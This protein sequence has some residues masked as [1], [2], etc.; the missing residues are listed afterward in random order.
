MG[1]SGSGKSMI[2]DLLQLIFVG[3]DAF[4]SATVG[5]DDRKPSGMVLKQEKGRGTDIAYAFINI[6]IS[7]NKYLSIGTYIETSIRSTSSF[8]IQSGYDP[9]ILTPFDKPLLCEDFL[10]NEELLPIDQLKEHLENNGLICHYWQRPKHYLE[11]LFNNQILPLNLTSNDK[12]L[13]DFAQI[14]QSF[15]RGKLLNT[16]KSA[17][18]KDFLFG[19]VEAKEI[20]KEFREAVKEFESEIGEYGRNQSEIERVT[21]KQKDYLELYTRKDKLE[22]CLHEWL[23]KSY[24]Y[25]Q[26]NEKELYK[27]LVSTST[28]FISTI[29]FLNE[30]H[31][32]VD[33]ELNETDFREH[34]LKLN[35]QNA[36]SQLRE[37]ENEYL[38]LGDA[39]NVLNEINCKPSELEV[40]HRN[41]L[42][43]SNKIKAIASVNFSLIERQLEDFFHNILWPASYREFD[44]ILKKEIDAS[45]DSINKKSL[46]KNYS[47]IHDQNSLSN[48]AFNLNRPLTLEEE[49]TLLHFQSLPRLKP[50]DYKNYLPKPEEL[51]LA[52]NISEKESAGFWLNLNGIREF[53][54]Y[55]EKRIFDQSDRNAIKSFFGEY[56]KE[57]KT[58]IQKSREYVNKLKSVRSAFLSL[59]NPKQSYELYVKRDELN[60]SSYYK[61][62]DFDKET[63][64]KYLS[65]LSKE[66]KIEGSYN[67]AKEN[68]R[69]TI[70]E[71]TSF[72]NQNKGLKKVKEI[73]IWT[74][75]LST[76]EQALIDKFGGQDLESF[77]S[78]HYKSDL[79]NLI[80]V[81][82]GKKESI[83][84][85]DFI[86]IYDTYK[87][88]IS[89]KEEALNK[90]ENKF[91]K[92]PN[93]S[94]FENIEFDEPK[95]E[96]QEYITAEQAYQA[97]FSLIIKQ[98][99][100][101]DSH[102]FETSNNFLELGKNLLPEV[103]R[104]EQ[105]TEENIIDKIKHYLERINEKNREL[106][107]RKIQR[108][109]D[110]VEE[111]DNKVTGQLNTVRL[112]DNFFKSDEKQITGGYKVRLKKE[113]SK[114]FP[115][116]WINTF[117]TQIDREIGL[118]TP[119]DGLRKNLSLQ[120][121]L[122]EMMKQ[123][124]VQCGGSRDSNIKTQD[125]LNPSSY[126]DLSFSM[127]SANGRTNIGST[128]Q[129][130]AA[131][132]MLCIARLSIIGKK[133]GDSQ[134][135]GIRFMP[136]D[137]AEGLG[138]N[139]EL[140]YDIAKNYDYQIVSM[141]VGSV[142]RFKE[143]DQ[144]VYILHK[145]TDVEAPINFTPMA[146][147]SRS[148]MHNES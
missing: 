63:L 110:I 147:F 78:T 95:E 52:L 81:I 64:K 133:E 46:L 146:I 72:E 56:S 141:S 29:L 125:L 108:I 7:S 107:S 51:I 101:N 126:F 130:Y 35:E 143:G 97:Q 112:I 67:R 88:T 148:D 99:L 38:L 22:K 17:S 87:T 54:P 5:T 11:V 32:W 26:Q 8:I 31:T 85:L 74:N 140:L 98:Y 65:C 55:L 83:K 19:D 3:S 33:N 43:T 21:N 9:A 25:F 104:N 68:H 128:G 100:S 135:P 89:K 18:L 12:I 105:V 90:Y 15:S 60:E 82:A 14:I 123:A 13:K 137:E 10:N 71:S 49:S 96:F 134:K 41:S 136:I 70:R 117:K 28:Q 66:K 47:D 61:A 6:A 93:L 2:G 75:P 34:E 77:D 36:H 131:I 53:V 84:S 109:R 145:N 118:F 39:K 116:E 94:V 121:G 120:V 50:S 30:V 62:L 132:A 119:D 4:E 20:T 144:Y 138:S 124:F 59:D 44:E 23:L 24:A 114:S 122:E 37:I 106:S 76:E 45:N 27:K 113:M 79:Q 111:I 129:T 80:E 40:L 48:W 69:V 142:G 16:K 58:D 103:L 86:L 102:K 73:S 91:E 127:E 1:D 115:L 42:E 92:E 57:L 139:Y